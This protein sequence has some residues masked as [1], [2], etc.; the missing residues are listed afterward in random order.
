M[1]Q[2]IEHDYDLY[3]KD[4]WRKEGKRR[5]KRLATRAKRM[6]RREYI[7]TNVI[8]ATNFGLSDAPFYM[9]ERVD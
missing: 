8:E 4:S 7:R 2:K 6:Q 9:K 5:L 1:D 3:L